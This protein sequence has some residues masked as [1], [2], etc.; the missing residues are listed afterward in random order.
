VFQGRKNLANASIPHFVKLMKLTQREA[1][2]F[3]LLVLFN[4]AK[5]NDEIRILFEKMLPYIELGARKIESGA[6]EYYTKWYYAAVREVLAYFPFNADY[7]S[8]AQMTVPEIGVREAKKAVALLL[9]LGF[10]KRSRAGRYELTSR[11]IT[12]GEE[13]RSIAVRRFQKETIGLALKA[14]DDVPK[15]Q[16]DIS[17]VTVT[18][19]E[20]GFARM[21]EKLKAFRR[22]VLELAHQEG[23]ADA[24]YHLNLQLIPIGKRL[25][26]RGA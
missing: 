24:A 22:E 5:S 12:T 15:E 20:D 8:L 6:Y 16:R 26:E 9:K 21:R 4:K 3:K 23:N 25:T 11:F 2:Y 18:L 10:I 13:W 19:S 17:T 7:A 14:L 1:E